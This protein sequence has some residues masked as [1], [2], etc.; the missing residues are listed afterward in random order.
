MKTTKQ[1][2]ENSGIDPTLVRAVVR[3]LGDKTYLEDVH[4]HGADAGYSGFTYYSDTVKF[5][6]AHRKAITALV[7]SMAND[8]GESP[9]DMVAGFQCLGGREIQKAVNENRFREHL[10]ESAKQ[11]V[12]NEYAPSVSRC[13]Y[14][15]R[16]TDEDTTVANA[17]AWFALEEV[18]RAFCDE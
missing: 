11:K 7:E 15:G 1:V 4:N 9:V 13:L 16:L 12:I 10:H 5:F 14:G 6:K 2:I 8:L 17:L 3:Q 18:A